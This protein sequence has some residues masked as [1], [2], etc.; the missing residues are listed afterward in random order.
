MPEI[1]VNGKM[2]TSVDEM[3]PEI[4]QAY[5]Q[6]MSV[7]ADKNQNGV[8]DILEGVMATDGINVQ[9]TPITISS[10]QF[11]VDGKTYSSVDELPPEARAKYEQAMAK[12]GKTA[13]KHSQNDVPDGIEDARPPRG[14]PQTPA[15]WADTGSD[16]AAHQ[17]GLLVL[18]AVVI[19]VLLVALI[20]LGTFV[21]LPLLK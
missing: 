7:L 12:L 3:P 4:R 5:E 18:A 19:V 9:T 2:Y 20:G 17:R 13:E 8:P 1:I 6:A 21:A 11:I 14:I 16:E 15:P 10:S